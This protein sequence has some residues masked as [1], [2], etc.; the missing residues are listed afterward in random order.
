MW[1]RVQ[2]ALAIAREIDEPT[3]LT[4]VLAGCAWIASREV[5]DFGSG[6]VHAA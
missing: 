5:V 2:H 4:R 6:V 3:L 1:E